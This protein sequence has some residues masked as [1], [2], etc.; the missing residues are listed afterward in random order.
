M[1]AHRERPCAAEMT[2]AQDAWDVCVYWLNLSAATFESVPPSGDS[3][4]P[5]TLRQAAP[6]P[7]SPGLAQGTSPPS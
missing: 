6:P 4:S 7:A 2:E 3:V 1:L 5:P